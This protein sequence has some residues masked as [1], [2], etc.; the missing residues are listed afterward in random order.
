MGK[1]PKSELDG[2]YVGERLQRLYIFRLNAS[3]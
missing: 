1:K 2:S 3:V